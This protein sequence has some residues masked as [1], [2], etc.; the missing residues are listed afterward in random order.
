MSAP[1]RVMTPKTIANI[2][3]CRLTTDNFSLRHLSICY[4]IL[5]RTVVIVRAILIIRREAMSFELTCITVCQ[6]CSGAAYFAFETLEY[7]YGNIIRTYVTNLN[8]LIVLHGV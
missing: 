4:P 6:R 3:S 1:R 2:L 5:T 7:H 8:N